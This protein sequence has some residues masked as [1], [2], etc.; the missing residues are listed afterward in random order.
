[1]SVLV[2]WTQDEEQLERLFTNSALGKR[3]KQQERRDYRKRTIKAALDAKSQVYQ[4]GKK[5]VF[6][7][8]EVIRAYHDNEAGDASLFIKLNGEKY[9]FDPV[10]KGFYIW[11]GKNWEVD[12]QK[13]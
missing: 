2:F 6:S 4:P 9:R 5:E 1:M 3:S 10:E 7:H 8:E 12:R 13:I 11:N